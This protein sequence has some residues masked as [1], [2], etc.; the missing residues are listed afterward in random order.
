MKK[1]PY[2]AEEIQ[3]E[4]IFC[5]FCKQSIPIDNNSKKILEL[6]IKQ[7][8]KKPWITVLLNLFPFI[9]GTGYIYIGN[10]KRFIFFVTI[11][12]FS[13]APMTW[14]G[15]REYNSLLLAA[16]WILTLFDGYVQTTNYN[17]K[18]IGSR[19]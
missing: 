8:E 6:H 3:D 10:W 19:G 1:C 5:R 15:L 18:S 16:I 12:L 17:K 7:K 9:L 13:F 4:A 2:C 11:Q 14:L